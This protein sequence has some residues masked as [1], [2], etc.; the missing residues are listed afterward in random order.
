VPQS[1]QPGSLGIWLVHFLS[2]FQMLPQT[3]KK[4]IVQNDSVWNLDL[5]ESN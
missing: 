5:E 3:A 1:I 2:F 4:N